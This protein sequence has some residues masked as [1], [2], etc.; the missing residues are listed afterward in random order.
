MPSYGHCQQ[1][2]IDATPQECFDVLTDYERLPEWQGAVKEVR[3]H[4]RDERGRGLI[5][6]YVVDAKVKTVR[7]TLRQRYEEPYLLGSE[8]IGGDFRDFS[9]EWRF[10]PL[11]GDRTLAQLDLTIDPG[12][13]VPGPI[14][15]V[16]SDAVMKRALGDLKAY[17][18]G[19]RVA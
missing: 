4:E 1:A 10:N 12:R 18:E 14:R 9:G 17:I 5:V 19:A 2:E 8:Y 6:E 15:S 7:Y 16:I 3:V 11:P 13:F